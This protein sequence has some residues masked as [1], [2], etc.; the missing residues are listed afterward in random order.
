MLACNTCCRSPAGNALAAMRTC[1]LPI[2]TVNAQRCRSLADPAPWPTHACRW[3]RAWAQ[4][5]RAGRAQ[6]AEEV[7]RLAALPPEL[8]AELADDLDQEEQAA[9]GG[10]P[11]EILEDYSNFTPDA[12]GYRAGTSEPCCWVLPQTA[13]RGSQLLVS[14]EARATAPPG[15]AAQCQHALSL[16]SSLRS[17]MQDLWPSSAAQTRARAR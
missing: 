9:A 4:V 17:P 2:S 15:R 12:P 5:R 7:L 13:G 6:K 16:A 8:A 11:P 14:A 1:S 3:R 10:R